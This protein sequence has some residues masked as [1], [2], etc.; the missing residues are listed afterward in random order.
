VCVCFISDF[1]F[2]LT[3]NP[4]MYVSKYNSKINKINNWKCAQLSCSNIFRHYFI[5]YRFINI[6]SSEYFMCIHSFL[7]KLLIFFIS[8]IALS[9]Y[10]SFDFLLITIAMRSDALYLFM[11]VPSKK[12]SSHHVLPNERPA[13]YFHYFFYCFWLQF[14]LY[15]SLAILECIVCSF[16]LFIYS[17]IQKE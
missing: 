2:T 17:W 4:D 14:V 1:L 15:S 11:C 3:A 5:C 10:C 6:H 7:F 8:F 12:E 16:Y 13:S 9:D